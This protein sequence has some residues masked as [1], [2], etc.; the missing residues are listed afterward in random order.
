MAITLLVKQPD[1]VPA[2]GGIISYHDIGDYLTSKEKLAAVAGASIGSLPW[3]HLTANEYHDWLNK[4]DERYS[5]LV[6]LADEPGAI[7]HTYSLGLATSRDVWV[8]NSSMPALR[9]TVGAMIDFYNEQVDAFRL[10]MPGQ[11]G[12]EEATRRRGAGMGPQRPHTVQ[13]GL[14]CV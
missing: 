1:P 4:R 9:R 7:F 14:R 5:Q 13:L 12:T 10:T 6:P 8:Y 11:P 2:G 3:Q